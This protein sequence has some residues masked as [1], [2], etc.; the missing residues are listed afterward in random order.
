VQFKQ[1]IMQNFLGIEETY[2]D[3]EQ[4]RFVIIP[5]PLERTTSYGKG[6]RLG[7]ESIIKASSYVELYDE[8]F[9]YEAYKAGIH[10]APA[11]DLNGSVE[12]MFESITGKFNQFLNKKQFAIGLGGEHAVSFPIYRAFHKHFDQLSV[13]QL[14]AHSDLR[15]SYEDSIYS[16]AAVMRRIYELNKNIVQVGIRSQCMEEAQFIKENSIATYYAHQLYQGGFNGDI[17]NHLKP[18]VYITIDLDYFDPSIMPST[19]TPEPGGG[20][21]YETLALLS[22]VFKKRNVVGFDVVELA[23]QEHV[24]HPDFLTAKLIY[25]LITLKLAS[26]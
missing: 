12:E 22:D 24:Y 21:W 6:T 8:E 7:P 5:V 23:P 16:H 13:L 10:T 11:I 18:N 17:I 1:V 14:D 15:D 3:A 9:G 19:G 4:S 26:D 20:L 25:K 2:A